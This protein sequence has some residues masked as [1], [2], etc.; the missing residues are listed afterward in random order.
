LIAI[1]H[2]TNSRMIISVC[3]CRG[4]SKALRRSKNF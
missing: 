4:S 1:S 2:V 3:P